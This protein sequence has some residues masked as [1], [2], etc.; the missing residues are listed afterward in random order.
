MQNKKNMTNINIFV[1]ALIIFLFTFFNELSA[2]HTTN[3]PCGFDNDCPTAIKRYIWR[4]HA[5]F[6]SILFVAKPL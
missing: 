3:I 5:K 6:Y 4:C 1:Y 2:Y